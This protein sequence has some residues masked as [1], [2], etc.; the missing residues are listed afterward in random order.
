MSNVSVFSPNNTLVEFDAG[1]NGLGQ[2]TVEAALFK[3]GKAAAAVKDMAADVAMAKAV[4]GRYRA[5]AE[6]L[7]VAFVSQSKAWNKLYGTEP[8]ANKTVFA[9]YITAM[10]NAAPGKNGWSA[11]QSI[12]RAMM[13]ALR[14]LPAFKVETTEPEVVEAEVAA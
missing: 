10:E 5:A 3:G 4:A 14:S 12:A 1:K 9:S 6:I 13:A 11:K 2:L 7:G 8:W